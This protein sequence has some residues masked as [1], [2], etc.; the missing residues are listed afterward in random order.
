MDTSKNT[1][2]PPGITITEDVENNENLSNPSVNV[3]FLNKMKKRLSLKFRLH[4]ASSSY[5]KKMHLLC[6]VPGELD[7]FFLESFHNINHKH[8]FFA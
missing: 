1:K 6:S 2:T 4:A 7:F 8:F 5:F 3:T